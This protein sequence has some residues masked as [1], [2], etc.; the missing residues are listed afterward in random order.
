MCQ[1]QVEWATAEKR[2]FLRCVAL[3]EA[4]AVR[5]QLQSIKSGFCKAAG[6]VCAIFVAVMCNYKAWLQLPACRQRIEIRLA[7][8]YMDLKDY[9]AALHLIGAFALLP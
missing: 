7:M 2:T 3:Q 8:L 4:A 9:P 6:S 5:L 1:E